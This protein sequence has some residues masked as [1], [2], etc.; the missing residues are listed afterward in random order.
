MERNGELVISLDFEL[1]WGVFD[2][3]DYRERANYFNETRWVIPRILRLFED[4]KISCTWATVGM[5]FNK[6]W[7]EWNENIPEFLPQYDNSDLSAYQF[8]KSIQTKATEKL[9]FAPN[10]IK[11][12]SQTEYQEIGTHT[13][14]HYYCLEP[15]QEKEAFEADLIKCIEMAKGMNLRL[16]SLV[17]PRNQYNKDY[18]ELCF[19]QGINNVRTNPSS[20]YWKNPEKNTLIQKVFRTGDAYLGLNSNSYAST[21]IKKSTNGLRLQ[22]ASRFLRPVS[23]FDFMNKQRI[24]RISKEMEYAAKQGEIYHLWWH[25][26]NFGGSPDKSLRDLQLI[27]EHFKRLN[28]AYSFQS[29]SMHEILN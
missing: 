1:L 15:G 12:I 25:P 13:Y 20:W 19:E 8:G 3:V 16:S 23:K 7:E 10:L 22:N 2:K 6:N 21:D 9:C 29:K 26:H 28:L 5:L 27:L 24:R 18:L 11:M 14:S 4:Y 17:F